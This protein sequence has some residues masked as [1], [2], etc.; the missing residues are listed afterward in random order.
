MQKVLLSTKCPVS[1]RI[2]TTVWLQCNNLTEALLFLPRFM[3][4]VSSGN[5][6]ELFPFTIHSP[7]YAML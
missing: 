5:L 3:G 4:D 7:P 6:A 2:L 1:L